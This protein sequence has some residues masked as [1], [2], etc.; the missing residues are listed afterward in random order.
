LAAYLASL[1]ESARATIN[2]PIVGNKPTIILSAS[3][4]QQSELE[5]RD[6]WVASNPEGKH[7][8][9]P[10]S[11]HWLHLDHPELVVSAIREVVDAVRI[12][13]SK[14]ETTPRR[15]STIEGS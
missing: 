9:V 5:E 14:T 1:P 4:A 12:F 11:G 15:S 3:S 10:A 6:A 8:R 7:V 2:L 13:P